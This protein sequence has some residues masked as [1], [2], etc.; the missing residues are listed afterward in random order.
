TVELQPDIPSVISAGIKITDPGIT[1][2]RTVVDAAPEID[3][4]AETSKTRFAVVSEDERKVLVVSNFNEETVTSKCLKKAAGIS[5]VTE[6]KNDNPYPFSD[7]QVVVLD[8][9]PAERLGAAR[10]IEL[11]QAV[12]KSGVGLVVFGGP[13]SFAAGAYAGTPLEKILPVWPQPKERKPVSVVVCL[14]ASGSMSEKLTPTET[15]FQTAAVGFFRLL[16]AMAEKDGIAVLS[17]NREA[18]VRIEF[19][20]VESIRKNEGE[21]RKAFGN[22]NPTGGT[23]IYAALEAARKIASKTSADHPRHIILF[24]DGK[25]EPGKFDKSA[26]I[27]DN[28]SITTIATGTNPDTAR[29]YEISTLTRGRFYGIHSTAKLGDVFL[30]ELN[31]LSG[32]GL[33]KHPT[34]V[35]TL[36]AVPGVPE[37]ERIPAVSLM[38]RTSLKKDATLLAKTEDGLPVIASWRF[39]LGQVYAA[40]FSSTTWMFSGISTVASFGNKLF[41]GLVRAAAGVESENCFLEAGTSDDK[42]SL[43]LTV[44]EPGN[45]FGNYSGKIIPPDGSE[46]S[47]PL[48]ITFPGTFRGEFAAGVGGT[49]RVTIHDEAETVVAR[50]AV[51]VNRP[52]ESR[53]YTGSDYDSLRKLAEAGGGKMFF[54]APAADDLEAGTIRENV[55]FFGWFL[56]FAILI[57]LLDLF[58]DAIRGLKRIH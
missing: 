39:G 23:D 22:I 9:N 18:A 52:A 47:V 16:S 11:E 28:I 55:H 48:A 4:D 50:G 26:F 3:G 24:S 27:N 34:N 6:F 37:N 46:F 33:K 36:S 32:S 40:P 57:Y 1:T 42:V 7:F 5:L 2:F 41:P 44:K 30:R 8:D 10:L 19:G 17:F 54:A 51:I 58:F 43:T 45:L 12:R 35:T 14:D 20:S 31:E 49:Y 53:I 29:L 25:S 38:N 21:L 15:K 13:N 56:I